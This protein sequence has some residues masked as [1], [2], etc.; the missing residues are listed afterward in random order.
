MIL[1]SS[2]CFERWMGFWQLEKENGAFQAAMMF[3][4]DLWDR[5]NHLV[6]PA[7]CKYY[8]ILAKSQA[9]G[10]IFYVVSKLLNFQ[11][12]S[13]GP[14]WS[15]A[16]YP[17]LLVP[18]CGFLSKMPGQRCLCI[19]VRYE[20]IHMSICTYVWNTGICSSNWYNPHDKRLSNALKFINTIE[21]VRVRV[22]VNL[23]CVQNNIYPL[24][25]G[26]VSHLVPLSDILFAL[27]PGK[28][29]CLILGASGSQIVETREDAL[30]SSLLGT[31]HPGKSPKILL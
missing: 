30:I 14:F 26:L 6:H 31:A 3:R 20:D 2:A 11:V 18:H 28:V 16:L 21:I 5:I 15:W 10:A 22:Y 29:V 7:S 23:R 25:S 27:V 24:I 17:T 13:F 19:H 1:N 4:Q 9:N 8:L 12:S